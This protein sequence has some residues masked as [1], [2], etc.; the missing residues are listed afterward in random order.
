MPLAAGLAAS[1]GAGEASERARAAEATKGERNVAALKGLGVGLTEL[2]REHKKLRQGFFRML[3]N[4]G[5]T[6]HKI[7]SM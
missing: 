7:Y 1:A 2:S 6:L 5:T 4:G 3:S